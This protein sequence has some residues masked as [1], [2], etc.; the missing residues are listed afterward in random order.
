MGIL[1]AAQLH[2]D[3]QAVSINIVEVLHAP[4]EEKKML[5]QM[6][7]LFYYNITHGAKET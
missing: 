7:Y 6:L 4:F 2:R 5:F 3:L 1:A